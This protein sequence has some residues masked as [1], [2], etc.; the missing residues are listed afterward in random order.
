MEKNIKEIRNLLR[1]MLILLCEIRWFNE[2]QT[3]KICN[4]VKESNEWE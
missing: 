2:E 3:K 1:M 4:K